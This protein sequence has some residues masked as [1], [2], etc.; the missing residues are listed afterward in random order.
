VPLFWRV[1][2]LNVSVLVAAAV[3][4]AV[5]PATISFPVALTEALILLAG[6][7]ALSAFNFLL[8]RRAFGP[9]RRLTAFMRGVDPLRPGARAPAAD[10]DPELA[11]LTDAFNEMVD[12]LEAERRDSA[13]RALA[14]QEAERIRVARELHDEV[15]QT[16]TAAV[17]EIDG[18]AR[19]AGAGTAGLEGVREEVR[20]AL[21]EVRRIA[22]RLRPEALD[23]LG[24]SAALRSVVNEFERRTPVHVDRHI[25]AIAGLS[26]EEEVVA[27]RVAQEA[28]TNV[29]RHADARNVRVELSGSD[30]HVVLAI[31]DDGRGFDRAASGDGAG[32]RGM[33]E[34]ALLAGAR[35]ELRSARG[36]GTRVR[37]QVPRR[38]TP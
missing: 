4:L 36:R 37:L 11:Q 24:L 6:V 3:L 30:G 15:G 17:L 8:L 26:P 19:A 25:A 27:Y 1:F 2:A 38:T 21:E 5:S 18:A 22:R 7:G 13:R 35:L 23:D 33:R 14:A 16:L 28:L 32:L 29:A 10:A 34:R 9:M 12:R 20:S 31:E